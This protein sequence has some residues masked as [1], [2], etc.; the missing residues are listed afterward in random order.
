MSVCTLVRLRSYLLI[1][2]A[3]QMLLFLFPYLFVRESVFVS[4][5]SH[6]SSNASFFSFLTGFVSESVCLFLP[7]V[8]QTLLL[9]SLVCI[10]HSST[11]FPSTGEKPNMCNICGKAFSDASNLHKHR[12]GHRDE[13]AWLLQP[14]GTFETSHGD[15]R[16][17]YILS[18]K[19]DNDALRALQAVVGDSC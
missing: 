4:S 8:V 6:C 3:V 14:T 13:E 17:I 16:I 10:S 7:T 9:F 2:S 18:D 19:D 5:R 12:R 1:P 15:Q 11:S